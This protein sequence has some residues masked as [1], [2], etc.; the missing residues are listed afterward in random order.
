MHLDVLA[1]GAHPDDV[2]LFCGGSLI[3][4]AGL[5]LRTGVVDLTAG[6][7]GSRGNAINRLEEARQAGIELGL[8]VRENAGM[9]D[10]NIILSSGNRLKIIEYIRKYTPDLILAPY[11]EDRHPDHEH[12]SQLIRESYFYAGLHKI[13]T[14][15]PAFRPKAIVY[16][17]QHTVNTPTFITDISD[18]FDLKIKALK[19]YQSQF[20]DND[21]NDPATYISSSA[22]WDFIEIRARY[23]GHQIGVKYGEP[24]FSKSVLK[25][26]NIFSIFA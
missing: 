2:E 13:N 4:M 14:E 1:F 20:L 18:T 21:T 8:S 17:F 22:F 11:H 16:Y 7:L 12:A 15:N 3:K 25:I 26:D 24:F 19:S 10:G 5:G 9:Q 23:F 6:E